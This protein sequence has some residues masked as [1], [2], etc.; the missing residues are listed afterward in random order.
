[1]ASP[2]VKICKTFFCLVMR[3]GGVVELLKFAKMI[4]IYYWFLREKRKCGSTMTLTE[5][6]WQ[7]R[8]S[9]SCFM[10]REDTHQ[11]TDITA[12]RTNIKRPAA[13]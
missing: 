4:K 3:A 7:L 12:D 6:E 8:T 2:R 5:L 13:L 9:F 1:M 10:R 11:I